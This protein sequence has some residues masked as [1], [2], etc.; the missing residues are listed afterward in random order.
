MEFNDNKPIYR[1]I[2]DHAFAK[3]MAGAWSPGERIPSVR[4]LSADLGVNTRTVL[5]ALDEL[6]ASSL[7]EPKRGM[8]FL[9]ASDARMKVELELRREFFQSTVPSL[10]EEMRRLGISTADL[11][12]YLP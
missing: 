7:I 12:P 2:V 11:L 1:Q 10:V 5:K 9:L 6:Q 8:G 4:E 3:I